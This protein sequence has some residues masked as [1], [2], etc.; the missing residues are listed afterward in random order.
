MV[1]LLFAG[2]GLNVYEVQRSSGPPVVI[3]SLGEL[4]ARMALELPHAVALTVLERVLERLR[5]S[6]D[7]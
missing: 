5:E 6:R 2:H 3:L 1:R 4:E 7:A